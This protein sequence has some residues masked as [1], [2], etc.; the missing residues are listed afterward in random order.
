M[1]LR[2]LMERGMGE[3]E[4]SDGHTN[5]GISEGVLRIV[6]SCIR[7]VDWASTGVRSG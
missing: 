4:R 5:D 7:P 6:F 3:G 2:E 1:D